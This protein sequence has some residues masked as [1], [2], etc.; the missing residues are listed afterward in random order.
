M[1]LWDWEGLLHH[2]TGRGNK[3]EFAVAAAAYAAADW[4]LRLRLWLSN[5]DMGSNEN[6]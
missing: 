4:L 3:P 1:G 6:V 2:R 5:L